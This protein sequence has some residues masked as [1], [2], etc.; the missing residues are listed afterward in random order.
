MLVNTR[1]VTIEWSQCDPAGIIFYPRYFEMFDNATT[2]LF[3][4]ALGMTKYRFLKHYDFLGYALGNTQANFILPL[5]FGDKATIESSVKEFRRTSFDIHHRV[6][7]NEGAVAAEDT[8]TRIWVARDPDNP[9]RIKAHPI[10]A[11]VI[12]KMSV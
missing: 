4:R 6:L 3:E 9:E 8:E 11:E 10:P 1:P 5:R 7:N 2:A 12:A